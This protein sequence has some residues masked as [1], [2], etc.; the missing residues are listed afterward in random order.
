[1]FRYNI[2][3]NCIQPGWIVTPMSNELPDGMKYT[4]DAWITQLATKRTG[5]PQE[6]AEVITFLCSDRASYVNGEVMSVSGGY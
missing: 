4:A 3:V 1:M 2:R 6:V 5:Q